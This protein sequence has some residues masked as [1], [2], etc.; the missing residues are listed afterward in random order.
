MRFEDLPREQWQDPRSRMREDIEK[1]QPK[2]SILNPG[3]WRTK[4]KDD[5][6]NSIP[7]RSQNTPTPT[8]K[9]TRKPTP[10]HKPKKK[11]ETMEGAGNQIPKRHGR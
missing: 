11:E 1:N 4:N 9:P 6:F 7:K 10:A 8:P 2:F 3:T 5:P